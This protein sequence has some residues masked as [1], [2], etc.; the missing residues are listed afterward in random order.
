MKYDLDQIRTT[1]EDQ[2]VS[3]PIITAVIKDLEQAALEDQEEKEA[4]KLPQQKWEHLFFLNNA[5]GKYTS[6]EMT[7]WVVTFHEG[8]DAGSVLQKIKDSAQEQNEAAKRKKNKLTN[9][10]EVFEGIKTKFL[11]DKK[12][13]V[14]T[15]IAI[16][17]IPVDGSKF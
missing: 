3:Q 11:K 12:V 2:K 5:D 14:K 8:T 10:G 15:K 9:L 1:L 17:V 13:K 7:G 4:N 16:R 6:E